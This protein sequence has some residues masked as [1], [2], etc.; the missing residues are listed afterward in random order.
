MP[1]PDPSFQP[2]CP[3]G[4]LVTGASGR[5]G[6]RIAPFWR[7]AP[8]ALQWRPESPLP[9]GTAGPCWTLLDG[10]DA[11]L[12]W[13]RTHE[14]P[15]ALLVLSGVTPGGGDLALNT[16]L[17]EA[18]LEAAH[19]A[20]IARVLL[21]SSAAVY[22]E[23]RTGPWHEAERPQPANAYGQA[24][25]AMERAADPW[26]ER[27]LDVCCLRLGNVAGADALLSQALGNTP[28][29]IDQFAD[30]MSPM[31]S[32]I[33]PQSLARVLRALAD[34]ALALPP[35]LNVAAPMPVTMGDL[36]SAAGLDWQPRPAPPTAIARLTLDCGMVSGLAGFDPVE[37]LPETIVRQWR[38]SLAMPKAR[39]A[40]KTVVRP[41]TGGKP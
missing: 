39:A 18:A 16:A 37:S 5:V 10:P 13:L 17:A 3:P 27:G 23:G 33:G 2:P 36:A 41:K 31:R 8:V 22:G 7:D 25:L 24:K 38:A 29:T 26:R 4:L 32:Y 28:L 15:A 20:G 1:R 40:P 34:P 21:A 12:D 9:M 6:Q 14:R 19:A 30:G 11:L 35:A